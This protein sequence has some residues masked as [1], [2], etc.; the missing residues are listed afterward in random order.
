M[1]LN[2]ARQGH[3]IWSLKP[4]GYGVLEALERPLAELETPVMSKLNTLFSSGFGK[5]IFPIGSAVFM[6]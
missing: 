3:M 6:V 4:P 1:P 2:Q 5:G